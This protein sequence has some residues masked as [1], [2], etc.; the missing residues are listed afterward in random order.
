M[1][2]NTTLLRA[3]IPGLR[4]PIEPFIGAGTRPLPNVDG[5]NWNKPELYAQQWNLTLAGEAGKNTTV[6]LAYVGNRGIN[7]RRQYNLNFFDPALGRR[8]LPQFANVNVDY[9]DGQ[10]AY[11]A[12]QAGLTKRYAGGI[13]GQFNYTFGKAIDN[14]QDY[15]RFNTQPQDGRCTGRCERGLSTADMRHIVSYQALWDLPVGRNRRFLRDSGGAAGWLVSGWQLSSLA[16][17]HS[18]AATLVTIGVNTFGNQNLINQRPDAVAGVSPYPERQS[19]DNF[20]NPLAF[21]LP[22]PGRFG[23]L[24]RNYA[25]GP[26]YWQFD[27]SLAKDSA[28]SERLKLRFRADVFNLLNRPNFDLPNAVFGTS[29]F[30][31]IFNTFGRTLGFGTSRQIQLSLRLHF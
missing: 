15:G 9:N 24:A 25:H 7:I 22:A 5:F 26:D 18:G 17:V 10:S 21:R 13:A 27:A 1:A 12:L 30:G 3:Q 31:R 16:L 28:L 6:Q 23:N 4:Y 8:P 20:F 11:H 14:A 29:N 19:I 2:G